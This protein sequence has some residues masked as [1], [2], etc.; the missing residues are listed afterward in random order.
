MKYEYTV[1]MQGNLTYDQILTK[2]NQLGEEGWDFAMQANITLKSSPGMGVSG[3]TPTPFF[4]M[5]RPKTVL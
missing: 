2:L 3:T 1:F 5:K 4:Y